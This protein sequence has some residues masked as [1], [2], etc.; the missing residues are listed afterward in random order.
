M[1]AALYITRRISI[2]SEKQ[3]KRFVTVIADKQD[4]RQ[5]VFDSYNSSIAVVSVHY[6]GFSL[7]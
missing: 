5:Y 3:N 7:P 4:L 2:V 6:D 1:S